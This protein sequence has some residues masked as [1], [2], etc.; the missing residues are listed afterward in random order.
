MKNS[1]K[2]KSV[3]YRQQRVYE[4]VTRCPKDD[5]QCQVELEKKNEFILNETG[6]S[7]RSVVKRRDDDSE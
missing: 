3:V 4:N 2:V 5:D 6:E 7:D 1:K